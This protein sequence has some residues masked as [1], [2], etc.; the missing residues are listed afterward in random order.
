MGENGKTICSVG[1]LMSSIS[2]ALYGWN[3][4]IP[5]FEV[6][7]DDSTPDTLNTWLRNNGGYAKGTS[8][9]IESKIPE[10]NP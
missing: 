7:K 8:D 4:T 5:G 9:L 6:G 10:I 1:C 2:E 3:I